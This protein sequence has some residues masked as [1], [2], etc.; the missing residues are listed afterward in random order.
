MYHPRMLIFASLALCIGGFLHAADKAPVPDAARLK[1]AEKTIR[2]LFKEDYS[3]NKPED[4]AAL[5]RKLSQQADE[6]QDDPAARYVAW[7]EASMLAAQGGDLDTA[8]AVLDKMAATFAVDV[9]PL[10]KKALTDIA[11]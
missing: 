2:D 5:A 1:A 3:K 7:R 4:K 8:L 11:A 10:K 9:A 6:T